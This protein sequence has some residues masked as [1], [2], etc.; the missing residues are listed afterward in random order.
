MDLNTFRTIFFLN[1]LTVR[2]KIILVF[3]PLVVCVLFLSGVIFSSYLREQRDLENLQIGLEFGEEVT[4]VIHQIQKERGIVVGYLSSNRKEFSNELVNQ[5]VFTDLAIFEFM[6]MSSSCDY[7]ALPS[8]LQSR[9]SHLN[10]LLNSVVEQRIELDSSDHYILDVIDE[11]SSI[12]SYSI[13][14]LFGITTETLYKDFTI[15]TLSYIKFLEYQEHSDIE[16]AILYKGF[17]SNGMNLDEYRR[18]SFEVWKQ[19]SLFDEFYDNANSEFIEKHQEILTTELINEIEVLR[20]KGYQNTNMNESPKL[21]YDVKSKQQNAIKNVE[22]LMVSTLMSSIEQELNRITGKQIIAIIL[23]VF[24]GGSML[25]VL[26]LVLYRIVNRIEKLSKSVGQIEAGNLDEFVATEPNDELGMFSIEINQML[27]RIKESGRQ[28]SETEMEFRELYNTTPTMLYSVDSEGTIISVSDYWLDQMGYVRDEVIGNPIF[29]FFTKDSGKHAMEVVFPKFLETHFC[30]NEPFQLQKKNGE[31]IDTLLSA[32]ASIDVEGVCK[33]S[34]VVVTEVKE[35]KKIEGDWRQSE[36]QYRSLFD[37]ITDIYYRTNKDDEIIAASP[38][39]KTYLGYSQEE[40]L[41]RKAGDLVSDKVELRKL[42]AAVTEHRRIE[43]WRVEIEGKE[44]S[45]TASLNLVA[46]YNNKGVFKGISAIARNI[47]EQVIAEN[48][49]KSLSMKFEHLFQNSK[50]AIFISDPVSAKILECNVAAQQ[51]LEYTK[52]ELSKLSLFDIREQRQSTDLRKNIK[53][54][55]QTGHLIYESEFL[56]KS[57]KIIQM[58]ISSQIIE[59]E[60]DKLIQWIARDISQRKH[61]EK[62]AEIFNTTLLEIINNETVFSDSLE[63]AFRTITLL[64]S[65]ALRLERVSIWLFDETMEILT[66][67][68]VRTSN[69]YESGEELLVKDFPN[70][71]E[72]LKGGVLIDADDALQD[73]RT[74][75][76]VDSVLRSKNI[77]SLLDAPIRVSGNIVGAIFCDQVS[78]TRKWA[79]N[80][81]HFIVAVSDVISHVLTNQSIHEKNKELLISNK[82][83]EEI[84][85]SITDIYCRTDENFIVTVVSPSVETVSGYKPDEI[86]GKSFNAFISSKEDTIKLGVKLMENK[87]VVDYEVMMRNSDGKNLLGRLNIKMEFDDSGNFIGTVGQARDITDIKESESKAIE[88]LRK[89]EELFEFSND[90]ILID[91]PE[92]GIII[93]AN[94]AAEEMLNY[95]KAELLKMSTLDLRPEFALKSAKKH[96]QEISEKGHLIYESILMTKEGQLLDAEMSTRQMIISNR[97]CHQIFI[98]DTTERKKAE[99]KLAESESRYRS[100]NDSMIDAI[101]ISDQTGN[102]ISWNKAAESIFG[103]KEEEIFGK[104]VTT[105]IPKEYLAKHKEGISNFVRKSKKKAISDVKEVSG[106]TKSGEIIPVEI[107]LS[108]W[109]SE[110]KYFFSAITRDITNRKKITSDL[111]YVKD[112][113]QETSEVAGVGGWEVNLETNLFYLSDV[114]REIIDAPKDYSLKL[115]DFDMYKKGKDRERI[116]YAVDCA[117]NNG[118][119]W[120]LE[121]KVITMMGREIWVHTKGSVARTNR[122]IT[123]LYGTFQDISERKEAERKLKRYMRIFEDSITEM[124]TFEEETLKFISVNSAALDNL[125]YTLEEMKNLS[126]VDIAQEFTIEEF[127]ELVKPLLEGDEKVV[128]IETQHQRK[129]GTLYDAEIRL[130]YYSFENESSFTVM[131]HDVTEKRALQSRV[132][133]MESKYTSLSESLADAVIISDEKGVI[134]GWNPAAT[135]IFGYQSDEAINKSIDTVIP[136]FKKFKYEEDVIKN[137]KSQGDQ[138]VNNSGDS[139]GLTKDG[140]IVPIEITESNW[141]SDE[142]QYFGAVIRDISAKRNAEDQVKQAKN[143]LK[144]AEGLTKMGNWEDD[145]RTK[146]FTCS[147]EAKHIFGLSK[148]KEIN[149]SDIRKKVHPNDL[150]VFDKRLRDMIAG[151]PGEK[152]YYRIKVGSAIKHIE[153]IV[154]YQFNAKNDLIKLY[155][156]VQDVTESRIM[157]SQLLRKNTHL[158]VLSKLEREMSTGNDGSSLANQ[159]CKILAKE[160]NYSIVQLKTTSLIKKREKESVSYY[161]NEPNILDASINSTDLSWMKHPGKKSTNNENEFLI[162]NIEALQIYKGWKRQMSKVGVKSFISIPFNY[163]GLVEGQLNIFSPEIWEDNMEEI[164][165]LKQVASD[166]SF[167]YQSIRIKEE[168]MEIDQFNK[169][170]VSSL[171]LASVSV[172]FVKKHIML[173]GACKLVFGYS[174]EE[175]GNNWEYFL[176]KVHPVDLL[177]IE[178]EFLEAGKKNFD[179]EFRFLQ[180]NGKYIWVNS[181]SQIELNTNNKIVGVSGIVSN[182]NTKKNQEQNEMKAEINGKDLER[183][184]IAEEIHD[185]L[186][187][188][189]TVASMSLA[190]IKDSFSALGTDKQIILKNAQNMVNKAINEAREISHDLLPAS[191][192]DFGL[193]SSLR[194]DINKLNKSGKINFTLFEGNIE[195]QLN[196]EIEMN[197]Y[198]IIKE[199]INNIVKHSHGTNAIIQIFKRTNHISLMIEDDG[200]GLDQSVAKNGKGTGMANIRNRVKSI[201]GDFFIESTKGVLITIE[202]PI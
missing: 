4:K 173:S 141:Y 34:Y 85:D 80:E 150:N 12:V 15:Q 179:L 168:S 73:W 16:T 143:N 156:T 136:D 185:S 93:D 149:I 183:K 137:E 101:I 200:V 104:S 44:K 72:A 175:L 124:F 144:R 133:E 53:K 51:L 28:L 60:E 82:K 87:E 62:Q 33:K 123:R 91:D 164:S 46:N 45:I 27:R 109:E 9:V 94:R 201:G 120:D 182:I 71:F 105:I 199:A 97:I 178:K 174:I 76:F 193:I 1:N 119:P 55:M 36:K 58:E 158:T 98:R 130:E 50:D 21:W 95:S 134:V 77:S 63:D 122:K 29:D 22:E 117:I 188:T 167:G 78:E 121:L 126:P 129:N 88:S 132:E 74:R 108:N 170:L 81:K 48:R 161:I 169:M 40:I 155:G 17:S 160:L 52:Q 67:R 113:L 54:I 75:E 100:L 102:I 197:L 118:E 191:L 181:I 176:E 35:K 112:M 43:N 31:V 146:I 139:E 196:L 202:V 187:Q 162:D 184:R 142:I 69:G 23:I 8:G 195:G 189:L 26:F 110:G 64:V 107:A 56:T 18:F 5:K 32:V 20:E 106:L 6:A 177:T 68:C 163:S 19:Q 153:S 7:S 190:S 70:Y 66:C 41:G 84:F 49:E 128:L 154:D 25:T 61:E 135:R 165:L 38:S 90:A 47:T 157:K 180:K 3:I 140:R 138:K 145:V 42:K 192:Q 89:Y 13:K 125:G 152:L 79:T 86:I 147:D 131:V 159:T 111:A 194:A 65:N 24:I 39:V 37:S 96:L 116:K 186:G 115:G 30:S 10:E 166:F 148:L 59:F 198:R 171:N 172:D 127:R 114:L 2:K 83:F 57:G 99:R 151:I 11:Y 92:T 14:T 103:Y